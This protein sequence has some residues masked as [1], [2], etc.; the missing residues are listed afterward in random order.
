MRALKKSVDTR[1]DYHNDLR[2]VT[3]DVPFY[4]GKVLSGERFTRSEMKIIPVKRVA[5]VYEGKPHYIII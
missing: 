3:D 5:V 1:E 4:V 2:F